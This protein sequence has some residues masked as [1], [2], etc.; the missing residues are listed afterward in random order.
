M[1]K[2][3]LYVSLL[4][5]LSAAAQEADSFIP[6][7]VADQQR[8]GIVSEVVG[9]AGSD[10]GLRVPAIVVNSPDVASRVIA[11]H[12]GILKAWHVVG[13]E[14][15]V[16]GQRLVTLISPELMTLEESWLAASHE[17]A[18]ADAELG[19]DQQLFNEGI[20]SELR[21]QKTRR[22]QQRAAF[23]QRAFQVQLVQLGFDHKDLRD[24]V[25]GQREPGNYILKAPQAG[26]VS[27][28]FLRV[29][30]TVEETQQLA[31]VT[32]QAALW[33]RADVNTV[34]AAGLRIGQ[35]LQIAEFDAALTLLSKNQEVGA[36]S[37]SI[38]ILARFDTT[39]MTGAASAIRPG[40]RVSLILSSSVPGIYVPAKA[41]THS[42]NATFVYISSEKGIAV[43][44]VV[45]KPLGDGYLAESG[46]AANES[47]VIS[48]T[49]QL[50]GIQLGLG[51]G[52]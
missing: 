39:S 30:D 22:D 20:I 31:S 29:G 10:A 47:L 18:T 4:V 35:K 33:L 8:L 5:S 1:L 12:S 46:I 41:V 3:L 50:K 9:S 44:E 7:S 24:L 45:L 49:A 19:K 17:L 11:R 25:S 43:R 32:Q 6:L 27:R 37:Q 36:S 16:V 21:L 38:Q 48:G 14:Q 2:P 42:E 15:V 51:G 40:Q 28:D 13:G 34:L 52:E 26:L 23:N